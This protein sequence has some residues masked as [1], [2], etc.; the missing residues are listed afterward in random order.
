VVVGGLCI[1]LST[2]ADLAPAAR[3]PTSSAPLL[4][5]PLWSARRIPAV[6]VTAVTL[7]NLQQQLARVVA[8]FESCVSVNGPNGART[9]L[10]SGR[11]LA[12]ASTQKLLIAATALAVLGARYRFATRAVTDA[13][14]DDGTLEGDLTIVGSG[15]PVLTTS[16]EPSTPTEPNTPLAGLADAIVRAGVRRVEG[17][18][19]ADDSRYDRARAVPDWK[20]NYVAEGDVGA[21]GALIVNGGRGDDGFAAADPALETVQRLAT[22]LSARGVRISGGAIDP[23]R[24]SAAHEHEVARVESPPLGQIVEQMLTVSNDETAELLTRE[25]GRVRAGVG[26]TAAGT[27][28]I[29]AVLARL[30]VPVGGVVLHDGSGLAPDDRVTCAA[31]LGA[32]ALGSQPRFSAITD[33]LAVAGQSGTL[34]GRLVGT[35]L[36]GRLRAKTGH[37]DDVVGLAGV[38]DAATPAGHPPDDEVRARFAFLANGNFSTSTGES[39]QNQIAET[40]GDYLDAPIPVDL[41]PRPR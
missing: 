4:A 15:D 14:L 36:A 22:L 13:R 6:L 39:L 21:L 23:G 16:T 24:A 28:V 29:P 18:L 19:V 12:G 37:I 10:G 40:I 25:V 20:P 1:G 7:S 5:T 17:A 33:G 35:T 31:L 27:H 38:I 2:R 11:T 30:G 41:V 8:P 9:R 32:L 26:T 34:I 3:P